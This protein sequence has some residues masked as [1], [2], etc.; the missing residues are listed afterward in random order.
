[1]LLGEV[2]DVD[3]VAGEGPVADV[4]ALGCVMGEFL[5]WEEHEMGVYLHA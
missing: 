1:M 4:E 3:G 2:C 5:G